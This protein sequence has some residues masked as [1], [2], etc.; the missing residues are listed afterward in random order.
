M[1]REQYVY[2]RKLSG[3]RSD[4]QPIAITVALGVP[5]K[6]DN[7]NV[8]ICPAKAHGLFHGLANLRGPNSWRALR[9]S[10]KF[11]ASLLHDFL[12]RG[13]KLYLPDADTEMAGT[14]V[15]ELLRQAMVSPG[16]P[17]RQKARP[18]TELSRAALR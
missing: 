5:Y 3:I 6:D 16:L 14:D 13:G 15:D 10:Q 7:L 17:P 1:N 9:L 8:W 4:S 18:A 11:I 12:D 2:E